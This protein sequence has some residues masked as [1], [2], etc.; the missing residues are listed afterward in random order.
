MANEVCAVKIRFIERNCSY[1]KLARPSKARALIL[2]CLHKKASK[3]T[4]NKLVISFGNSKMSIALVQ[5]TAREKTAFGTTFWT[6]DIQFCLKFLKR[7]CYYEELQLVEDNNQF[8]AQTLVPEWSRTVERK[9][10]EKL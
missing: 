4:K 8:K 10:D 7:C 3:V 5:V 6:V 2:I 9:T 1:Q